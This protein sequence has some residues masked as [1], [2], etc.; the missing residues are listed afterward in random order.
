VQN[1]GNLTDIM[2]IIETIKNDKEAAKEHVNYWP[3]YS[4]FDFC[5]NKA[6]TTTASNL[7]I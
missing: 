7:I 1:L 3:Q 4:S 5:F 6:S 2:H